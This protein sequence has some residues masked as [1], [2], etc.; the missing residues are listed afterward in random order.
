MGAYK[1]CKINAV[2]NGMSLESLGNF[3]P[4]IGG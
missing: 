3:S 1:E 2:G 4:V